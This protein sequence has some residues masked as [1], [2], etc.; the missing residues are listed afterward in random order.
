MWTG[1]YLAWN[2]M[3][4]RLLKERQQAKGLEWLA[5]F[6]MFILTGRKQIDECSEECNGYLMDGV[7]DMLNDNVSGDDDVEKGLLR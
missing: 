2:G 1:S 4:G 3:R 6:I 7:P 5:P